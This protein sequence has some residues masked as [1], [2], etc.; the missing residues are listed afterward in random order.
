MSSDRISVILFGPLFSLGETIFNEQL[1]AA[2]ETESCALL[3][4]TLPQNEAQQFSVDGVTNFDGLCRHNLANAVN[5]QLA[6]AVLDGA[7]HDSGT[8]IEIGYR[9]GVDS[10]N[11]VVGLRTDFRASED[12]Q[13]NAMLRI[14]NDIVVRKPGGSVE[15]AAHAIVRSLFYQAFLFCNPEKLLFDFTSYDEVAEQF[16]KLRPHGTK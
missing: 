16:L 11:I 14:C 7:D 4:V 10:S 5:F 13:I 2:I 9:K 6:V 1:R 3:E 8:C 15:G 12:D